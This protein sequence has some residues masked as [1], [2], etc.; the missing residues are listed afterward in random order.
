MVA[1]EAAPF[2]KTGGLAD[3]VGSLP[4]ALA[5]LGHEVAVLLPLYPSVPRDGARRT[6]DRLPVWLGGRYFGTSLLCIDQHAVPYYFLDCPLLY[7]REGLYGDE[8]GDHADNHLR[9]SVLCRAALEVVRRAFRPQVIHC[10]DWQAGLVAA[11]LSGPLALDPTFLGIRTLFTVH[12]LG[13][14]GRFSRKVLPDIGL[15][16]GQFDIHGVELLGDISFLKAGL[17]YSDALSTVSPTYARE[18][19]TPE[20]GFGLDGLLRSRAQVLTGIVNGVDYGGWDPRHDRLI[21]APYSPQDL[22][23][24][25]VCKRDLLREFGLPK[26]AAQ[27]PLIGMV[28]RLTSQKGLDLIAE[29]G[30]ILADEQIALVALGDG[31]AR[32]VDLLRSLAATHPNS[33]GVQIG[34]DNRLAHKV[35][36]GAD[37]FLMPSHY[38]PCGLNQI[39]SLR[40]GTVPVVRATGGLDDTIDES[41]GFKFQENSGAALLDAI[42][43][44][45]AA[46][47]DRPGWIA[48]MKRGMAKDFSWKASAAGYTRL[49]EKLCQVGG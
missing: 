47:T 30:G 17:Y 1:S 36:A 28:S 33:I 42:R 43:A 8:E 44:E 11:Y 9:F 24:K 20:Q 32:Y 26:E 10:H 3:V 13:Y 46:Y 18:I 6:H 38:E 12:N 39:Y 2:A 21:A 7:D 16:P 14:Q 5:E 35:E 40:Y 45:V 25:Q 34:Y 19:Q 48:R 22:S 4:A 27:R 49:Y 29:V 15:D 37:I 41:T 31:E 23:G